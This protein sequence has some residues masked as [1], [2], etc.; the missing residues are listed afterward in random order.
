MKFS[1]K[2]RKIGRDAFLASF[3]SFFLPLTVLG[4]N[5]ID[6]STA[7]TE[8]GLSNS[9]AYIAA[10]LIVGVILGLLGAG[11]FGIFLYAGFLY[12]TAGGEKDKVQKAQRM[13][14]QAAIGIVIIAAS[15]AMASFVIESL[16]DVATATSSSSSSSSSSGSGSGSGI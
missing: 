7:A 4:F 5:L 16:G 14:A 1:Q 2:R 9:D 13:M 10:G 8:T 3:F 15:Y 12:M 6:E 11:L